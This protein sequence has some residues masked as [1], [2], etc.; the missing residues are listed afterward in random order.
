MHGICMVHASL[1]LCEWSPGVCVLCMLLVA[2]DVFVCVTVHVVSD[3]RCVGGAVFLILG[4]CTVQDGRRVWDVRCVKNVVCIMHMCGH[5]L[6]LLATAR[7]VGC[8]PITLYCA[9]I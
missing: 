7:P 4:V 3:M 8:T 5:L 6:T 1:L 2:G 9:C